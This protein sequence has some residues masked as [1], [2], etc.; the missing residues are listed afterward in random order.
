VPNTNNQCYCKQHFVFDS[1][2]VSCRISCSDI[3]FSSGPVAGTTDQCLC[4]DNLKFN[5]KTSMC[6][7]ECEALSFTAGQDTPKTCLCAKGYLWNPK[8]TSCETVC[9]DGFKTESEE[10]DDGNQVDNDSCSN[11][12]LQKSS[13]SVGAII[14]IVCGAI[15]LIA[16]ASFLVYYFVIK[17]KPLNKPISVNSNKDI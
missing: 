16:I 10:C 12:C 3:P 8:T 1:S 5:A 4:S 17:K 14:G 6:A 2:T 13:V 7:I 9:G 11:S 15:A